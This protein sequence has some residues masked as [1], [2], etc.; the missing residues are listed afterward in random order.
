MSR[1]HTVMHFI[2]KHI[3]NISHGEHIVFTQLPSTHENR[4]HRNTIDIN[5]PL[6]CAS[7]SCVLL[8]GVALYALYKFTTYTVS[9]KR[10]T[11]Y[12]CPY[13]C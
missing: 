2:A 3:L 7:V 8:R 4:L 11:L 9:Q 12:S 6:T 13:L 10:E 5:S 1:L